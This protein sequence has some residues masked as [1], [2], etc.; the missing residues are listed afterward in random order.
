MSKKVSNPFPKVSI[1]IACF[2]NE[3]TIKSALESALAQDYP[4]FEII[5]N[6]DCSTDNTVEIV[7]K[8]LGDARIKFSAN[9]KN[10]GV[11]GNFDKCIRQLATGEYFTMVNGDDFFINKHFISQAVNLVTANPRVCFVKGAS[12]HAHGKIGKLHLYENWPTIV[13]CQDFFK[14]FKGDTDFGFVGI[15]FNRTI[16]ISFNFFNKFKFYGMD[17]FI[18][19]IMT[20]QGGVGFIKTPSYQFNIHGGN[21]NLKAYHP[22]QIEIFF[23]EF[24]GVINTYL[25]QNIE[26]REVL[27]DFYR[28][29]TSKFVQSVLEFYYRYRRNELSGIVKLLS[30][31]EYEI[32]SNILTGNRWRIYKLIFKRDHVGEWIMQ[33]KWQFINSFN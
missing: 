18:N 32:T 10:L 8:Y 31:N 14:R 27:N 19:F 2:N 12:Y 21:S 26:N 4:N 3:A 13:E 11:Y 29:Y 1:I 30:L 6:D 15:F 23:E 33:K 22:H 5:V 7:A 24:R 16:F 20:A 28:N 25:I 9:L 17:Y